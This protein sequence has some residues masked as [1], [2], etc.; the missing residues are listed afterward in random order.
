MRKEYLL[1]LGVPAPTESHLKQKPASQFYLWSVMFVPADNNDNS[2][3]NLR[4]PYALSVR[5]IFFF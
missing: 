2:N 3:V 1:H 4:I 5:L